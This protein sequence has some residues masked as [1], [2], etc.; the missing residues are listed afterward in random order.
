MISLHWLGDLC[1]ARFKSTFSFF[2]VYFTSFDL[3]LLL[4]L[5]ALYTLSG[6]KYSLTGTEI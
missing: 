4:F 3:L 2:V 6:S 5:S 1:L